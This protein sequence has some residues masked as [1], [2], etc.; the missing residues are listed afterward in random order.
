[1]RTIYELEPG[2]FAGVVLTIGN[3]DGVHRGH[4]ALLAVG[5]VRADAAGVPLVAMTFEPHPAAVLSP[6]R[7]P[8]EL[9][10]LP[11][12]LALLERYGADVAVV[13]RSEPSFFQLSAAQFIERILWDGFRPIAV[14]EGTSFRFGQHRLGDLQMLKTAG[15]QRGFEL[16]VVEPIRINLGGHPDAVISSSLVRNLLGSGTV[17]QADMCLGRLYALIG[18]V[19]H[20]HGRGRDLGFP[21]A[22]VDPGSQ[23]VPADGIYAGWLDI[24]QGRFP[25]AISVGRKPTFDETDLAVEA[26]VLDFEGD[27]YEQQVRLEFADWVRPQQRFNTVAELIDQI[28]IDVRDIRNLLAGQR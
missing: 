23:L 22:N 15:Q 19:V 11:E 8:P 5:R 12:K 9:T 17:D 4:Q 13:V 6:D 7:V 14:V 20:G 18:R 26:F 28:Q 24:A 3:F 2:L 16:I 10:P 21:T 1:M 27:L 25:A